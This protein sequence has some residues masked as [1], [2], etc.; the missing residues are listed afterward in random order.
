MLYNPPLVL[1]S[2]RSSLR[3][4]ASRSSSVSQ[5]FLYFQSLLCRSSMLRQPDGPTCSYCHQTDAWTSPFMPIF[6]A[7][8][9]SC[10]HLPSTQSSTD[11]SALSFSPTIPYRMMDP[12]GIFVFERCNYHKIL[13][14]VRLG[15]IGP[16][17][18]VYRWKDLS[19]K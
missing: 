10:P 18:W 17:S 8:S 19:V 2:L 15:L 4:R 7:L 9:Y 3:I 1:P 14:I 11:L 12:Q 5:L 16:Q 6:F 13:P